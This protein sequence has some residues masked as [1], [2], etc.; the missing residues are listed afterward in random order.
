MQDVIRGIELESSILERER[1]TARLLQ[2]GWVPSLAVA[3]LVAIMIVLHSNGV[4]S[5]GEAFL[6]SMF[7]MAL[8]VGVTLVGG[9]IGGEIY[10]YITGRSRGMDSWLVTKIWTAP[11]VFQERRE[12]KREEQKQKDRQL[13]REL[14]ELDDYLRKEGV[15]V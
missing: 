3:H 13:E 6:L 8:G 11:L 1:R 4:E 15:I 5:D 2:V 12:T 10:E 9:L 14:R 7:I